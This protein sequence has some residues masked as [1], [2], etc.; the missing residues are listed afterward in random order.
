VRPALAS[1]A[2]RP[3]ET[4]S[5]CRYLWGK[6]TKYMWKSTSRKANYRYVRL[7][8]RLIGASTLVG[9]ASAGRSTS[10]PDTLLVRTG[11]DLQILAFYSC[12][13]GVQL[14]APFLFNAF[15]GWVREGALCSVPRTRMAQMGFLFASFIA[16]EAY[17][18]AVSRV[19]LN[20]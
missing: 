14:L 5:L 10:H 4:G 6:G 9:C 2:H 16:M 11:C 15:L 12:A 20:R 7:V 19:G 8:H 1:R 17:A 18:F 13:L 3:R